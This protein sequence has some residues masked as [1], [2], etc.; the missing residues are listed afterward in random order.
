MISI[1][2]HA[3]PINQYQV[4]RNITWAT[5]N[6]FPL[7]M[8]I[9]TPDAGQDSCPVVIIYHGGGWLINQKEIMDSLAV[10]LVTHAD[11][12]V[13]NVNYRLLGDEENTI[14]INQCVEDALGA[15]IWVQEH[16]SVYQGDS[17]KIA[18]TG[19]S[20]GGQL[21][22]MVML[23]GN[24]LSALGMMAK[25]P[26]FNPT[27]LPKNR[28]V[29][30][31]MLSGGIKVQAALLSYPALDLY[32]LCK[33]GFEIAANPF[34]IMAG[35]K[36]R[37]LFGDTISYKS[38]PVW[39]QAVSPVYQIPLSTQQMLPPQFCMIGSMDVITP[40]KTM[41][42]YV[43]KCHKAGQPIEFWKYNGRPHAFLDSKKNPLLG[44]NFSRDAPLAIDKMITF[45]NKVFYSQVIVN[46]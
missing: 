15:V 5:P 8:D 10:Y 20:A 41:K 13:C 12:V 36:P 3:K 2:G 30:D 16:I 18:V 25:E 27:Y 17:T 33:T 32:K 22:A 35:Q 39:Y 31:V 14:G 42:S 1:V 11:Y 4:N 45:L 21:A 43:E 29:E 37:H 7:T 19:D 38:H 23:C 9:Y 44:I 40:V 6:N 46:E 34:W 24:N 28:S 26:G